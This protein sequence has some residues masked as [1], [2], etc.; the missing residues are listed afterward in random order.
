MAWLY[1]QKDSQNWWIGYRVNGKAKFRSTATP[2]RAAA[3]RQ[4]EQ[5]KAMFG[6]HKSGN[7]TQ[8]LFEALTA[9]P[10]PRVSLLSALQEWW[11]A[12]EGTT[13]G[14]TATKYRMVGKS[15]AQFLGATD[16]TPL[17]AD[18]TTKQIAGYL[19]HKWDDTSKSTANSD[20]K[21]LGVF[22][23]RATKQGLIKA[24]PARATERLRPSK[25]E[26]VR[27]RPFTLPELRL[28]YQKAPDDF[29]RYM[30]LGGFYTSQRMGDLICLTWDAVDF[31]ANV[32][33]FTTSKTERDVKI[34]LRPSFRALLWKLRT[35]AGTVAA[36]AP[37]WPEQAAAYQ[38]RGSGRFSNEFYESILMPCGLVPPRTHHARKDAK[39]SSAERKVSPI[40][41]HSLRH[42]HISLLK[43]TGGSQAVAKEIAGHSSDAINDHYTQLPIETLVSAINQLPDVIARDE[44]VSARD[45]KPSR[46]RG[47]QNHPGDLQAANHPRPRK[48][49]QS[50][51]QQAE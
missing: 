5:V 47:K 20:R 33:S 15:F 38:A 27:K 10:A 44:P 22:F 14:R 39:K 29:W 8:E 25:G 51:A 40:S 36:G 12:A 17:L 45:A 48:P 30:V 49:K 34:P 26:R 46:N 1:K 4:L 6:A 7:L 50:T 13:A 43:A 37:I 31:D 19:K 18:V 16:A 2:D 28:I 42:A 21:V 9:K 35:Q 24:N 11:M 41:F 3:E 23:Q 32:L